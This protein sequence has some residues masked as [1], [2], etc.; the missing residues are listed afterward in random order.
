MRPAQGCAGYLSEKFSKSG[1]D[2]N[3]IGVTWSHAFGRS[4]H[5]SLLT[6]ICDS[7]VS[8]PALRVLHATDSSFVDG[9]AALASLRAQVC[10]AAAR[11][12]AHL[13]T[14]DEVVAALREWTLIAHAADAAI[15]LAAARVE[16]C[17]PPPSAGASTAAEFVAMTTGTTSAKAKD[18]IGTGIGLR[19]ND[20]TRRRATEGRLSPDQAAAIADVL[21]V[22]PSAEHELLTVAEAQ[23]LGALRDVCAK[24]KAA[25]TDMA[26]RERQIHARRCVRRYRDRDGAEHLHATGTRADMALIDQALKPFVDSRFKQARREGVRESLEA[27]T[28]DALLDLARTSLDGSSAP[29]AKHKDTIR[30][31]GILRLDLEALRRGHA[32]GDEL[33]EIVGL[34]P[35]SVERAR[36]A[37]SESILKLVLTK[38]VDVQNVTHLGRGPNTAQK[39]ALLWQRPECT[40]VNCHRTARLEHDHVDGAEYRKTRHTRLDELEPLCDPHHDLKTYQ[41]WALIEGTGKRPFVPPDDPRHPRYRHDGGTRRPP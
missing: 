16:E 6:A 29:G 34:G 12:H 1:C 10:D 3:Y 11:F 36:E 33:C 39:V 37:L 27:Y 13:L 35:I 19:A 40:N 15:A 41:G 23:P 18:C 17:G 38:G 32:E 20:E 25:V 14:R 8:M 9:P 28:F 5:G 30:Y 7:K 21:A 31:L 24:S 22:D 4:E 26:E 2:A